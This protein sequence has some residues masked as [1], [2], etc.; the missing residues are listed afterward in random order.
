[1]FITGMFFNNN[2]KIVLLGNHFCQMLF[3]PQG[4]TAAGRIMS[5]KNFTNN[6]NNQNPRTFGLQRSASTDCA[7]A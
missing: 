3:R 7:T 4:Q 6:I 5:K 2:L 1:M